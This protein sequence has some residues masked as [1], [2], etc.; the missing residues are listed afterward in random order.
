MG[1]IAALGLTI[2]LFAYVFWPQGRLFRQAAKTRLDYLEERKTA[3][4]DNLRDLSFEYQAGKYPEEDYATQRA[5]LEDEAAV[6]LTEMD[7][8]NG[9]GREGSAANDRLKR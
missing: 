9:R 7:Q 6:I 5:G 1:T 2:V 4:Y 8:L 3:V